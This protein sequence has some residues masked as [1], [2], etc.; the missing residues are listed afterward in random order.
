MGEHA[1]VGLADA[2]RGVREELAAAMES[3]DGERLRFEVGPVE[4]EFMV[5]VRHEGQAEGKVKVWVV[6]AGA[7]G[8][9]ARG[10]SHTLKVVL[11]P[12]DTGTGAAPLVNDAP[13]APPPRP[14]RAG[15]R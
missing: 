15:Q 10:S 9:T 5:E 2:V 11:N 8:T 3:A 12:V 7:S 6:E 14:G 13:A 4:L 1:W